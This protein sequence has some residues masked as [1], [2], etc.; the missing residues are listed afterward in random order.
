MQNTNTE[1]VIEIDL[2][3]LVMLL[4]H[5]LWLIILCGIVT[6]ALGFAISK[7]AIT[8]M[9]ESTTKV[10]ILNK[11]ENNTLTYSDVQLGTQLTADYAQLIKGRD[12][13]EQ[14]ITT[15]GLTE[16]Y[17]SFAERV[18]VET[19]TNTRII[20][21][22]VEDEDPVMAQ[23]IAN[24]IRKVAAEHIKNVMDIQAVNVAEEANLPEAPSSP[25]I[26][27]WTVIGALL[28]VFLC[29]IIVVIKF[30]MDDTIKTS[31]DIEKY[32][33]LS[34]LAI[35][36]IIGQED[37]RKYR[38]K[39]AEEIILEDIVPEGEEDTGEQVEQTGVNPQVKEA[40]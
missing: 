38:G 33:G 25:S 3:E 8:P 13:L 11:Q 2:Q 35:I 18:T 6:G 15:C 26:M 34:T 36:P 16:N 21:I 20:A 30:L 10:Y 1:D 31:E 9:Y 23:F 14:I 37:K 22:T 40:N 4:V 29:A 28:G 24:E 12:V 39:K 19:L 7:F 32:L 27:K 5:R 17:G